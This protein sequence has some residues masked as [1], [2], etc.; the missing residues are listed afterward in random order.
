M[1]LKDLRLDI[2]KL[3][4]PCIVVTLRTLREA[5]SFCAKLAKELI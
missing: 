5:F 1:N 3:S 2:K 4:E